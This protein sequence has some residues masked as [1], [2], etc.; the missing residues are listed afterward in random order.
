MMI[1]VLMKSLVTVYCVPLA[2]VNANKGCS[3]SEV[4]TVKQCSHFYLYFLPCA[5][6]RGSR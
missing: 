5:V 6:K 4:K 3:Q 1:N 2:F